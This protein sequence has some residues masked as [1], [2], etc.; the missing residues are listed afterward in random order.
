MAGDVAD[1]I[2]KGGRGEVFDGRA[3]FSQVSSSIGVS[4]LRSIQF[5]RD[6]MTFFGVKFKLSPVSHDTEGPSRTGEVIIAC[7]GIGYSN[8]KKSMA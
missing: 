3:Y 6:M 8:V 4:D 2:G 1:G 7:M 5:L